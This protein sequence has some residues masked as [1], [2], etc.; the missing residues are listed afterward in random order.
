VVQDGT[1]CD[2]YL[3]PQPALC[4]R[5][6]D[7][8]CRGLV[9][10]DGSAIEHEV[11]P[12]GFSCFA[13]RFPQGTVVINGVLALELNK[14]CS[15]TLKKR[16]RSNK[17]YLSSLR[18]W[19]ETQSLWDEKAKSGF[20]RDATAESV[21]V[22]HDVKTM[23][24]AVMRTCESIVQSLPGESDAEKFKMADPE[25]AK[26]I[27][28]ARL[29]GSLFRR[30][31]IYVNPEA[32]AYGARRQVALY[33]LVDLLCHIFEDD[34]RARGVFLT[35]D[36]R[37]YNTPPVYDSME[38]IPMVLIDN[39]IKYSTPGHG[40]HVH[41][42]DVDGDVEVKVDS[43][44][45]PVPEEERGKI[46]LRGYRGTA[47]KKVASTG[48]GLGLYIAQIVAGVHQT[49][50]EYLAVPQERGSINRFQFR[51]VGERRA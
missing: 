14:E 50:V 22:L 7:S 28:T 26:L 47:A 33:Q 48:S 23:I 31:D 9:D 16:F 49:R 46:F 45:A 38:V 43:Y 34:A 39:A 5:C 42:N 1:L 2:G 29:L 12:R 35:L 27:K 19:K 11:C 18:A 41:V 6:R 25:H 13:I 17:V 40:V 36:G 15:P 10:R 4:K 21:S 8:F 37:S 44:G 24:N 3:I 20:V 30:V 51:V 32:A